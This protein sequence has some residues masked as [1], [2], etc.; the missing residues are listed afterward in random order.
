MKDCPFKS[1]SSDH[2]GIAIGFLELLMDEIEILEKHL[3]KVEYN[4]LNKNPEVI[5]LCDIIQDQLP[6]HH[7]QRVVVEKVLNYVIL[8]KENQY[9][10]RNE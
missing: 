8:N 4:R 1:N 5:I 10:Y 3:T 6:F 2:H 9:Y 7:L